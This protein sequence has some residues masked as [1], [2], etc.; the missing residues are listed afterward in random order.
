MTNRRALARSAIA[1][2]VIIVIVVAAVG[3]FLA[4]NTSKPSTVTI[5]FYETFAA[6]ELAFMQHTI[7]PQFEA[8]NPGITV[9]VVNEPDPTS[10]SSSVQAL[11][12]GNDVGTTLVGIDNL[13]V[14]N[15]IYANDTMDLSSVVGTMEPSGLISS[16][17][18]MV[19]YE[20]QV[21]NAI[22][23][24]P[25]RSNIPLTWYSK[26]A[27]QTA[28]ITSPPTTTAQLLTDA[29]MLKAAGYSDPVMFQGSN[30]GASNPTELYQ[31]VVQFGGNPFLL[32]DSG[33]VAAFQYLQQLSAY[34]NPGYTQA[35]FAT[36]SGLASGDYQ[37]LDYQW[38]YIY[39]LL[40]NSTFAMTSS[41][42]GVYPGPTG[43]ANG[44]HLLGGD[45]L[46]VP[47][48]ATNI[49]DIEKLANFLLSATPQQE[50]LVQQSWVA[51]NSQAYQNLPANFT[52]VGTALQA[53]ISQGVFLR[54][55]SPWITQ[56][57]NIAYDAFTKIVTNH[58][59][60]SS[61]Q[62][63]LNQENQ[64]MYSYIVSNYGAAMA[65]QYEQNAFKPI[66]VS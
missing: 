2:I 9:N 47:K 59:S 62:T 10:V 52:A 1:I 6:S 21:Y 63:I 4:T 7:I 33:N 41:T 44:N 58:A 8:A 61:I 11:V 45:V 17:Q 50:M 13:V 22:Y 23:F 3:I 19:N 25:F 65:Q 28:G 34:F 51:V 18:S 26:T 46:V 53:A 49:A 35:T 14:G 36:Y 12:K 5:N 66:S 16:A 30:N 31:W 48:G 56:W 37:I 38:P 60:P 15:L 24:L 20:K 57:T 39:G 43:P 27:F 55:P 54:N 64:Q 29:Q 32:N 40:T 42:L